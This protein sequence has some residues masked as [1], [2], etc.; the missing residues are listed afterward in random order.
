[1]SDD[2]SDSTVVDLPGRRV[3]LKRMV[4]A[5]CDQCRLKKTVLAF[6]ILRPYG[7][8]D[9]T[10][11]LRLCKKCFNATI[12]QSVA[13]EQEALEEEAKDLPGWRDR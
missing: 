4:E 12:G 3:E 6:S 1:M 5:R 8:D 11:V 2:E 10:G 9:K 13:E 7:L